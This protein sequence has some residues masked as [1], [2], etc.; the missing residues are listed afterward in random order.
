MPQVP[1][2][3]ARLWF[4]RGRFGVFQKCVYN[5][6][7]PNRPN[8][9]NGMFG[10]IYKTNT[11]LWLFARC[12]SIARLHFGTDNFN[13][14]LIIFGATKQSEGGCKKGWHTALPWYQLFW[15]LMI[16]CLNHV[17][18]PFLVEILLGSKISRL[19]HFPV[20]PYPSSSSHSNGRLR[21][22]YGGSSNLD[23]W[24]PWRWA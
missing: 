19:S 6:W 23:P 2:S 22:A 12:V 3:N 13:N 17:T 15:F 1:C 5:M 16:S 18:F 20:L 9:T 4:C 8:P 11:C 7:N 24:R 14:L 21:F 10:G